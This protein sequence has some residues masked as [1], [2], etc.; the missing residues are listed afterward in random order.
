MPLRKVCPPLGSGR[1]LSLTTLGLEV[2][3]TRLLGSPSVETSEHLLL[4]PIQVSWLTAAPPTAPLASCLLSAWK[5][6]SPTFRSFTELPASSLDGCIAA[7]AVGVLTL[8]S[9]STR[10]VGVEDAIVPGQGET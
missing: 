9:L 6:I 2:V 5:D 8:R 1:T 3:L 4:L 10:R 7:R